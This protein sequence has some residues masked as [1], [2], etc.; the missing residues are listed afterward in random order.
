MTRTKAPAVA[1][2]SGIV[3]ASDLRDHHRARICPVRT[4][5]AGVRRLRS[6]TL[7]LA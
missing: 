4:G 7:P 3:C 1:G 6:A 5:M 2:Q